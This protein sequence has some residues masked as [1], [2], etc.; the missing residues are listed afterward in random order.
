MRTSCEDVREKKQKDFSVSM[1][2]RVIFSAGAKLIFYVLLQIDH[3]PE[4]EKVDLISIYNLFYNQC[5]R[6]DSLVIQPFCAMNQYVLVKS[7]DSIPGRVDCCGPNV[8]H[9]CAKSELSDSIIPD[10]A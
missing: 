1:I 7:N 10:C 6:H 3:M 2:E 5:L 4:G 8:R 9:S